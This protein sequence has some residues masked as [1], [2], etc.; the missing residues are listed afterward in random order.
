[1][2]GV[3]VGKHDVIEIVIRGVD[4]FA[5]HEHDIGQVSD[6]DKDYHSFQAKRSSNS[7]SS[8]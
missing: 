5:L 4:A 2:V 6:L 1:M 7:I 3:D 8:T